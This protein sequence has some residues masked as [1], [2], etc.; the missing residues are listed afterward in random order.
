MRKQRKTRP[1]PDLQFGLSLYF[2]D[3]PISTTAAFSMAKDIASNVEPP[4]NSRN[5]LISR[6]LKFLTQSEKYIKSFS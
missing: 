1:L 4:R 2:L 5:T 3:I 6:S